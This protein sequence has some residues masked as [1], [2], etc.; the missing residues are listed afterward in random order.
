V[1]EASALPT[2]TDVMK[3]LDMST[4]QVT[5]SMQHFESNLAESL[6]SIENATVTESD[7]TKEIERSSNRYTYFQELAQYVN[8]LGEFLDAK[9]GCWLHGCILNI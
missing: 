8:D 2:L 5:E 6:K 7:L 3:A 9:V 4:T 1:P